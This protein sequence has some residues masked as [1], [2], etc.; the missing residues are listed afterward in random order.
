[1]EETLKLYLDAKFDHISAE[2]QAI[3]KRLDTLNGNVARHE[4]AIGELRV[5]QAAIHEDCPAT[6]KVEDVRDKVERLDFIRR[7][8]KVFLFGGV[9]FLLLTYGGLFLALAKFFKA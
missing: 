6:K 4:L 5:K 9:G 2:N 1:M 8:W 3:Q 7:N